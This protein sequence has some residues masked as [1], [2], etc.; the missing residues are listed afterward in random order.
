MMPAGSQGHRQTPGRDG[1]R[2]SR[3]RLGR[4]GE[5]QPGGGSEDERTKEGDRAPRGDRLRGEAPADRRLRRLKRR[6]LALRRLG[7]RSHAFR[8]SVVRRLGIW[9]DAFGSGALRRRGLPGM[10]RG[11]GFGGVVLRGGVFGGGVLRG[12]GLGGRALRA[13]GL[14]GGAVCEGGG[15]VSGALRGVAL[16]LCQL[17]E[18]APKCDRLRGGW[19]L[20]AFRGGAFRSCAFRGAGLRGSAFRGAGLRGPLLPGPCG[21]LAS[22]SSPRHVVGVAHGGRSHLRV[23][24]HRRCDH[25]LY[26]RREP[27]LSARGRPWTRVLRGPTRQ[28]VMQQRAIHVDA[29]SFAGALPAQHLRGYVGRVALQLVLHSGEGLSRGAEIA[30]ARPLPGHEHR[31]R[32]KLA[33]EDAL[34]GG[35]VECPRDVWQHAEGC[36]RGQEAAAAQVRE[37]GRRAHVVGDPEPAVDLSAVDDRQQ[38]PAAGRRA[39]RRGLRVPGPGVAAGVHRVDAHVAPAGSHVRLAGRSSIAKAVERGRNG[40]GIDQR[41]VE[42]PRHGSAGV[43]EVDRGCLGRRCGRRGSG[44]GCGLRRGRGRGY[45]L[46]CRSRG[47]SGRGWNHRSSLG[48]GGG[49]RGR[50]GGAHVGCGGGHRGRR[51]G[52]TGSEPGERLRRARRGKR[53][54]RGRR[55]VRRCRRRPFE[56]HR[57]GPQRSGCLGLVP[58]ATRRESDAKRTREDGEADADEGRAVERSRGPA[59]RRPHGERSRPRRRDGLQ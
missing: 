59:G 8:S 18:V 27:G 54:R 49:A 43:V 37:R 38:P 15:P 14:R 39:P 19:R 17:S 21:R 31:F 22:E 3:L 5:K 34:G 40:R 42:Q 11:G 33:G 35:P 44:L 30:Q 58:T 50:P 57:Q 52:L 46:G 28:Q 7:L 23:L 26:R 25:G 29:R 1:L 48:R 6:R 12:R 16:R 32:R 2:A 45:G 36:C 9:N 51:F 24:G 53:G 41:A 10:L 4:S 47:R 55:E 20:R 13:G 56:W